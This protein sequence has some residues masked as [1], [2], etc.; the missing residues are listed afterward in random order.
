MVDVFSLISHCISMK[1]IE[2]PMKMKGKIYC[3][4]LQVELCKIRD[5]VE[6]E[7]VDIQI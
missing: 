3:D 6:T 7:A 5:S 4:L 1:K 2:A